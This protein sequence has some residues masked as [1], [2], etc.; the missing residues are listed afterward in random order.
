M[1]RLI[2]KPDQSAEE[3]V[4]EILAAI[5]RQAGKEGINAED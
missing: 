4:M 5:E 2:E 3:W 1:A